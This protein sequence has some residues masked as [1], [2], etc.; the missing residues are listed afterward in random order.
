MS[1]N[2]SDPGLPTGSVRDGGD[3]KRTAAQARYRSVSGTA[4]DEEC[5]MRLFVRRRASP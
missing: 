1:S 2:S 4:M 3:L 5:V